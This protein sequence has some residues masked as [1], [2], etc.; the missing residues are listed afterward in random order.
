MCEFLSG[1]LNILPLRQ[2]HNVR[3]IQ[4]CVAR[5]HKYYWTFPLSSSLSYLGKKNL[6]AF[7]AKSIFEH[8]FCFYNPIL[9]WPKIIVLLAIF[10]GKETNLAILVIMIMNFLFEINKSIILPIEY[11]NLFSK[12][13]NTIQSILLKIILASSTY[14]IIIIN[15]H[16][17]HTG[18]WLK[19][20]SQRFSLLCFFP[21]N[22]FS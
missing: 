6:T 1:A 3:P 10:G 11:Q 12:Y 4:Y 20:Q 8:F 2:F 15:F 5:P 9:W 18:I 7:S 14:V 16:T 22:S 21:P 19:G 13:K 17:H